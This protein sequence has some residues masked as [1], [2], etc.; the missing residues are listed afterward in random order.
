MTVLCDAWRGARVLVLAAWVANSPANEE[1][2]IES[3]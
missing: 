2:P 1:C 3:R